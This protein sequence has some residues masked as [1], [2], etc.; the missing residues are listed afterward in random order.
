MSDEF[1]VKRKRQFIDKALEADHVHIHLF[2]T[3][4]G[5]VLPDYLTVDSTISLKL[6][7]KFQGALILKDDRIL[8]DLRFREGYFSCQI[9][10]SAIWACTTE[11]GEMQL[12]ADNQEKIKLLMAQMVSTVAAD[13]GGEREDPPEEEPP[14]AGK[15]PENTSKRSKRGKATRSKRDSSYLTRVK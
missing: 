6:S 4:T 5:V 15:E 8:V 10:Y 11:S 1:A 12:W 3:E 7:R 2:P 14:P 9:P 13:K